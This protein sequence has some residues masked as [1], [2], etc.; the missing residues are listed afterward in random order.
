[1]YSAFEC[2]SSLLRKKDISW[3]SNA[4]KIN[5]SP[6]IGQQQTFRPDARYNTLT[7]KSLTHSIRNTIAIKVWTQQ[8]DGHFL[9]MVAKVPECYPKLSI[10]TGVH[11]N[12]LL[13]CLIHPLPV[14]IA[15]KTTWLLYISLLF[16]QRF[17]M[18]TNLHSAKLTL[19][20]YLK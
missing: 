17:S 3:L 10:I 8:T 1:M 4:S 2:S 7:A 6:A 14:N 11:L 20:F 12:L 16:F 18:V 13:C 9:K 15:K 19:S 5:T